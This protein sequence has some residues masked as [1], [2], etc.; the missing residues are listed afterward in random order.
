MSNKATFRFYGGVMGRYQLMILLLTLCLINFNSRAKPP[1][2]VWRVDTRDYFEIFDNGFYSLGTNDD[3]IEHLTGRSCRRAESDYGDSAFISTTADRLFAYEYTQRVLRNR[4]A[5]GEHNTVVSIYQIRATDNMYSAQRSLDVLLSLHGFLS[6][7]EVS[8][9]IRF[10]S[11]LSEWMAFRRIEPNQISNASQYYLIQG[12]VHSDGPVP[13]PRFRQ[14]RSS[15]SSAPYDSNQ[16][17]LSA[18]RLAGIWMMRAGTNP[19]VRA[20]FGIDRVRTELKRELTVDK[21]KSKGMFI[22]IILL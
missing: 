3:V 10:S 22:F 11:H 17:T 8:R 16:T 5:R 18:L 13:N 14:T 9:I 12:N 2:I 20:C 6:N 7:N 1:D 4:E 19:L 21:I 15:A